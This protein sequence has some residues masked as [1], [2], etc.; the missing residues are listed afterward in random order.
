MTGS[1]SATAPSRCTS[2]GPSPRFLVLLSIFYAIRG[3]VRIESGRSGRTLQR[4]ALIDR[5]AHWLLASSFIVLALTGLNLLFGRKVI[6][7]A[8]GPEAFATMTLWGKMMHNYVGFAFAVA[9]VLVFLLWVANNIPHPRDAMW[10][11]RGGGLF[12]GG[13]PPAKK[14]NAGQK[15]IFWVVVLGGVSIT[16]SGWALLNPFTTTMMADTAEKLNL[17]GLALPTDL[18]PMQ[19]QQY[20]SIWHTAVAGGMIVVIIAH[21]YIGSVG[22]EGALDAMT[23]GEVDV[24]WAE[25]HHALWVAEKRGP[26][27]QRHLLAGRPKRGYPAE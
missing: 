19:E 7:P 11:L 23:T 20:Q 10:L 18:T 6:L 16:L 21:I 1:S 15:L 27:R 4:F 9:V 26:P 24:N 8:L 12:G 25:E 5:A 2:P 22:M 14:F 17:L 13:H 3:R